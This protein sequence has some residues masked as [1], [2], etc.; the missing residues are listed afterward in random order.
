MSY[1]AKM[2]SPL[3]LVCLSLCASAAVAQQSRQADIPVAGDGKLSLGLKAWSSNWR[4]EGSVIVYP[5]NVTNPKGYV[6]NGNAEGSALTLTP[7]LQYRYKDVAVSFSTLLKKDFDMPRTFVS[8][9]NASG[10]EFNSFGRKEYDLNFSYFL[11]PNISASIGYKNLTLNS[12]AY[13]VR[14]PIV[15]LSASAPLMEGLSL[16]ATVGLGALNVKQDDRF[17][18]KYTLTEV[19][20]AYS[21]HEWLSH[22]A[23]TLSY[24][25]QKVKATDQGVWGRD[26]YQ[27]TTRG[28]AV[29]FSKSF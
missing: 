20:V 15:G 3:A 8:S 19:G 13:T 9:D 25:E 28:V 21:L 14:G 5:N 27:D 22:S 11:K 16:Y 4:Q 1:R 18:V 2:L 12:G 26:R 23:V 29:G 10:T 7:T 17:D 6:S 24:R